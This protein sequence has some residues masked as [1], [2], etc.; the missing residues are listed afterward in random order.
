MIVS[1]RLRK[2]GLPRFPS[3][4]RRK[5]HRSTATLWW[6]GVSPCRPAT[7]RR[8]SR[9][10]LAKLAVY[11]YGHPSLA[12]S[13]S[14][15]VRR[16]CSAGLS[17]FLLAKPTTASWPWPGLR[18]GWPFFKTSLF[19]DAPVPRRIAPVSYQGVREKWKGLGMG[20]IP[21]LKLDQPKRAISWALAN[22]TDQ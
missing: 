15:F 5:Q 13:A 1:S 16:V 2:G 21:G 22:R 3:R 4:S 17:A 8:E 9:T 11:Q 6:R 12:Q 19:V 7:G 20:D 18:A 14:W 10:T